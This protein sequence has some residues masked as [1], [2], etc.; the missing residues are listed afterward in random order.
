MSVAY[1][2]VCHRYQDSTH[3]ARIFTTGF[4]RL[5][6]VDYPLGVCKECNNIHLITKRQQVDVKEV[7]APLKRDRGQ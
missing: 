1:C 4:I 2:I 7:D 5:D 3:M 6:R